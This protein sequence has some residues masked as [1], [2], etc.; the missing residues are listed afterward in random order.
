MAGSITLENIA[1]VGST[2]V[3]FN[4]ASAKSFANNYAKLGAP[5]LSANDRLQI[6][7][8]ALVYELAQAGGVNYKNNASGLIQDAQV[9]TGGISML[10]PDV[11]AAATDF[12][13]G[14]ALDATLPSDV[15]TLLAATVPRLLN[16]VTEDS[17]QRMIAFLRAQLRK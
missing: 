3:V 4:S 12:N 1:A 5:N 7:V 14:Q 11:A 13:G 15:Q 17:M 6:R 2:P 8:I 10:D 9:Y 16:A